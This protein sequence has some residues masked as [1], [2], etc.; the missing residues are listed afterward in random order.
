MRDLQAI[1]SLIFAAS[2]WMA[3]IKLKKT[4]KAA[5]PPPSDKILGAERGPATSRKGLQQALNISP[6]KE[7]CIL[8]GLLFL[9][10]TAILWN[11]DREQTKTL[12]EAQVEARLNASNTLLS[13]I[14]WEEYSN[15]LIEG[16]L[17]R[18][19]LLRISSPMGR[20][21][22]A[23]PQILRAYTLMDYGKDQI[24]RIL[25]TEEDP[26]SNPT[27]PM[28]TP[29]IIRFEDGDKIAK[30]MQS[31]VKMRPAVEEPTRIIIPLESTKIENL[32]AL[33]IETIPIQSLGKTNNFQKNTLWAI[34]SLIFAGIFWKFRKK[35]VEIAARV[36]KEEE[37]LLKIT[38]T[39]P[40]MVYIYRVTKEGDKGFLFISNGV[41]S[42][43][44]IP[45]EKA[46]REW[47]KIEDFVPGNQTAEAKKTLAK[48]AST[49]EPWLHLYRIQHP[50]EG[51]KWIQNHAQPTVEPDGSITWNGILSDI[52]KE[53]LTS[54]LREKGDAIF[55]LISQ[56][57][58]LK[59]VLRAV[60][61]YVESELFPAKMG[62][63][64]PESKE[65]GEYLNLVAAPGYTT[66]MR[67]T[68]Q[69][70]KIGEKEG[71]AAVAALT[72]EPVI[73]Q[74]IATSN[75][76][77]NKKE[78][79][80][81]EG[82]RSCWAYPIR[83]KENR[84]L[85][86]VELYR[87]RIQNPDPFQKE[88]TTGKSGYPTSKFMEAAMRITQTAIER[89][90]A[91]SD[92]KKNE[93]H[94]RT[95]FESSPIGICQTWKKP[96]R[97]PSETKGLLQES[98][99]IL[100]AN[101]AF[102]QLLERSWYDIEGKALDDLITK[103]G[104][105]FET[106]TPSRTRKTLFGKTAEIS[107]PDGSESKIHFLS[108]I[109]ERKKGEEALMRSKEI[110]EAANRAKSDFLAMM[111]HEIRTPMNGIIGY[112]ELISKTQLTE[113]QKKYIKTIRASGQTL[114]T[115]IN[116]ILNLSKIE[117][118][119]MELEQRPFHFHE[120]AEETTKLLKPNADKKNLELI[121]RIEKNIPKAIIGDEDRLKQILVNL[122]GNAIKFTEKGAVTIHI[123]KDPKAKASSSEKFPILIHII[124]TGIGI[125]L[126]SQ[127]RLF[128]PFSQADTSTSRR[129]GGTGLGLVISKKLVQMMGGDITLTSKEGQGSTF[130]ISLPIVVTEEEEAQKF[131]KEEGWAEIDPTNLVEGTPLRILV[132]EDDETNRTLLEDLLKTENHD[133]S[134]AKNGQ[135]ALDLTIG[136]CPNGIFH[137]NFDLILMDMQMPEVDGIQATKEI[138]AVEKEGRVKIVALTANV[139]E[140]DRKRCIDA[141][142]DEF[143]NK[144]IRFHQLQNIIRKIQEEKVKQKE[145]ALT[146]KPLEPKKNLQIEKSA[147][148]EPDPLKTPPLQEIQKENTQNLKDSQKK[149]NDD[150]LNE[151]DILQII[152][153]KN[154]GRTLIH[155][156][157]EKNQ[158][159]TYER[160]ES[161][162]REVGSKN[163]QEKRKKILHTLKGSV[164]T[165]GLKA[166]KEFCEKAEEKK[167]QTVGEQEAELLQLETLYKES[168]EALQAWI[169]LNRTAQ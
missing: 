60:V 71:N 167:Q 49:R 29:E 137:K 133:L 1:I 13:S 129:F 37:K 145:K 166:A 43:Y 57:R 146:E 169:I 112:A 9:T 15:I 3:I 102:C 6:L 42:L 10:G 48:S 104:N 16:T 114:L 59:E 97:T 77:E 88:A 113:T 116:D 99:K 152:G 73:V 151:D 144:P 93:E 162:K 47:K 118:G 21:Q 107:R 139:M 23:H 155:T 69:K 61:E 19:T 168:I 80:L 121:L 53:V 124:D 40:G 35:T 163:Y 4:S 56:G 150:L 122:G 154:T 28:R 66:K 82:V 74:D 96:W 165:L 94:Y 17:D 31:T 123:Q 134:F 50:Q 62:I 27:P 110:A 30:A 5:K 33:V 149:I 105:E 91:Q 75:F 127:E 138:R 67:E 109:T 26:L 126:K 100:Y 2:G 79:I 128:Q 111:S 164:G 12:Q 136:K 156:M 14:N 120:M 41:E 148:E 18:E 106:E 86:V 119:K 24:Y 89:H 103:K 72:N 140:A 160:L 36:A 52:T 83:N 130:T 158:K 20:I 39:V 117:A 64:L 38:K 63:Y 132:A 55:Q 92:L 45:A 22:R 141:G 101:Q 143:L 108:D 34:M 125:P 44:G 25:D 81:G 115:I 161:L 65:T 58:E 70:I 46:R 11:Q 153:L 159:D 68:L 32:G 135:E 147:T 84:L 78:I 131:K 98:E 157:M 76:W 85:A 8:G 90:Q 51:E 95:L 87:N 7:A 142:M 54:K